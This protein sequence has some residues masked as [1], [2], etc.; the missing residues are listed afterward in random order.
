MHP[1]YLDNNATTPLHP[2]VREAML[3]WIGE[4]Y[5]N[6]SSLHLFGQVARNAVEVAREKV[7]ALLGVWPPEIVF[8]AS[9]TEANNA[10]LFHRGRISGQSG[11]GHLVISAIEHPSIREAA[12]RLE[13]EGLEVTR[14]SPAGDG[15]VP[16][17]EVVRALRPET[18]LV[19][20]M[21]AN[22]ELGTLQPVAEVAKM[23]G[24]CRERGVP[25]LCDAVQAVGKIPVD[26]LALGVDYLVLGAHKFY[27]P[28]GAAALWV[29]KGVEL[30]GYLV[31]G[32]QE[33]RRRASTENV[34][35][36]V[37][38]GE[39]A[40]VA[41]EEMATRQAHLAALRDRFETELARR[42]PE[43]IFHCQAS[44]RLPNTSHV[45]IPGVEGESLLIRLDL[46]G[47][48]VSTGSACSSGAVE[49]SKTLLAIG[50]SPDEA[51]SSLRISFG[52]FNTLEEVDAFLDAL[53][54]EVAALR[55]VSPLARAVAS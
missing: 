1:V 9:G 16:A 10:V 14:V 38:L 37:G 23:A 49:P 20:L 22:N 4:R 45:A 55:R 27:G 15:V 8:T 24:G 34:P 46:A 26:P 13:K 42:M 11:P 36:I 19:A 30:T 18:R 44:P 48:A 12:A 6:P 50:L 51:L 43:A 35:A 29:R 3:P 25:V 32:S 21:L 41:R 7:A 52:L 17:E 31:G 28:L 47:F 5:G 53:D 40:A 2:R 33:R 54:R 39:A